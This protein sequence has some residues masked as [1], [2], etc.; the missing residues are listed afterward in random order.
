MSSASTIPLCKFI[1]SDKNSDIPKGILR[2]P[3]S[4]NIKSKCQNHIVKACKSCFHCAW[5]KEQSRLA[6]KRETSSSF[7]LFLQNI[8][9]L[10]LRHNKNNCS[11][12]SSRIFANPIF[13]ISFFIILSYHFVH[14]GVAME[15]TNPFPNNW[16]FVFYLNVMIAF[17]F[18]VFTVTAKSKDKETLRTRK[19]VNPNRIGSD[20]LEDSTVVKKTREQHYA[21]LLSRAIQYKTISYNDPEQN[22][23]RDEQIQNMCQF[24]KSKF[25]TVYTKFPPQI[26][27]NYSLLFKI[28]GSDTK[29]PF[30]LCSHLDVVPAPN[31]AP[32]GTDALPWKQDPFSGIIVDGVIWGRGGKQ[33]L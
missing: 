21:K 33:S 24:L 7:T 14:G 11:R 23:E 19:E 16:S 22:V 2:N 18:L 27:H 13:L 25:P 5:R 9:D 1:H 32:S 20:I 15:G 3:A 28:P 8:Y 6:E 26:I 4:T 10:F 31:E 30:M 17:M 29:K 12:Y